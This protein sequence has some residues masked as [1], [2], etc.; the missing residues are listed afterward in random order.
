[1]TAAAPPRTIL[2][3][4]A[5]SLLALPLRAVVVEPHLEKQT[6]RKPAATF[7]PPASYPSA[8]GKELVVRA[9]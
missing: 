8:E 3:P 1:M 6:A 4:V 9:Y 2:G 5:M 7:F